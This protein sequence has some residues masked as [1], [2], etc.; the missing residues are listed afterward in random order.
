MKHRRPLASIDS[1]ETRLC[2]AAGPVVNNEQFLGTSD[3]I[4]AVVITFSG[5]LDPATAQ[6]PD[7]YLFGGSRGSGRHVH[8]TPFETPVYDDA[9]HTVTLTFTKV[10][11]ITRFKRLKV[12]ISASK[13][14]EVSDPSGNLLDG[15]R[16]GAAGGDSDTRF[17]ISRTNHLH[18]KDADGDRVTLN[19]TGARSRK[20]TTLFGPN[21]NVTEILIRGVTN[22]LRGSIKFAKK[23]SD[24]QTV[25]GRIV[26]GDPTN[27]STLT[28][29][30]VIGQ[31]VID[32]QTPI[33]PTVV[34]L[35]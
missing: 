30:F 24:Q 8:K 6:N 29:P 28:S 1:L 20:M 5:S 22:T 31:T 26:L 9:A 13:P 12:I 21:R 7:N 17:K 3:D 33:D 27:A 15:D 34:T 14:G 4:S 25:I 18:Y 35:P 11:R 32:G 10:Y 23:G 19:L 2:F 16:D